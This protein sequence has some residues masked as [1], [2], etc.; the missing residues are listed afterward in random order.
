MLCSSLH[1]LVSYAILVSH[2]CTQAMFLY[3]C[4]LLLLA[5]AELQSRCCSKW[6]MYSVPK[7][8]I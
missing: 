7:P 3:L 8:V 1:I 6:Y 4:S 5:S 2:L